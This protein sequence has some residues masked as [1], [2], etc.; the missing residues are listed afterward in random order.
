MSKRRWAGLSHTHSYHPHAESCASSQSVTWELSALLCDAPS[1]ATAGRGLNNPPWKGCCATDLQGRITAQ[2]KHPQSWTQL[3][4]EPVF[5]WGDTS[6]CLVFNHRLPPKPTEIQGKAPADSSE[7]WPRHR[8]R[9]LT[10]NCF[11][12]KRRFLGLPPFSHICQEFLYNSYKTKV[13]KHP[14]SD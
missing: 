1:G 12:G 8:A 4:S 5:R 7:L 10:G 6:S 13:K 9:G 14:F 3:R 11:P 2:F